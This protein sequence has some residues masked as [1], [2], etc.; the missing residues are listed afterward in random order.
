MDDNTTPVKSTPIPCAGPTHKGDVSLLAA[1]PS[2]FYM[3]CG[4]GKDAQLFGYDPS[5]G[6][7]FDIDGYFNQNDDETDSNFSY[8]YAKIGGSKFNGHLLKPGILFV[9][10]SADKG[11]HFEVRIYDDTN[12]QA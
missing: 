7:W 4:K 10:N 9:E 2:K 3:I 1:S 12:F 11:V 6:Y 8:S 5:K